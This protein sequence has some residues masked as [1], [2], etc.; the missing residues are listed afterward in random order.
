MLD[1]GKTTT[2]DARRIERRRCT[3]KFPRALMAAR[4]VQ[5]RRTGKPLEARN[6]HTSIIRREQRTVAGVRG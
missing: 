4:W 5:S 3:W 1:R 2:T 6:E